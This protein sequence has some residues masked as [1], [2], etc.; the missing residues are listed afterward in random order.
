MLLAIDTATQPLSIALHDGA[1]L[2]AECTLKAD[3]RHSA[4]LAPLIKQMMAEIDVTS[5]NLNALAVSVGPGSYTGT[6]IGV[7]LAK[8]MAAARE[9]PL[10]PATTLDT[11]VA[12]QPIPRN[13]LPLIVTVS[14][15]RGRVIWAEYRYERAAWVEGRAPQI[16]DWDELLSVYDRPFRL[17]GETSAAGLEAIH[18]AQAAG[19]RIQM[20]AAA[21]RLRRAGF[22]AEVAWRRLRESDADAFP[23]D[24][25]MPLYLR[26]P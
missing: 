13:D 10:V 7:A 21:E 1:A 18:R 16:S 9:L 22:L 25:V 6:R 2:V 26:G 17:C 8:G 12:A 14:A 20:A 5:G 23:A 11:I 4:L 15:G 3:R 24:R 19:A